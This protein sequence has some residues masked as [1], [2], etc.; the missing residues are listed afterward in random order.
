MCTDGITDCTQTS[1]DRQLVSRKRSRLAG[2][3]LTRRAEPRRLRLRYPSATIK[4]PKK[5]PRT[6]LIPT[7]HP[8]W[9]RGRGGGNLTLMQRL[10]VQ[11]MCWIFPG[12]SMDLNLAGRSGARCGTCRSPSASASTILASSPLFHLPPSS[13]PQSTTH[14]PLICN[15]NSICSSSCSP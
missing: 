10:P 7:H 14:L 6:P 5:K 2:D 4:Q 8:D 1:G 15:R 11:M 13:S 9:T 3:L 12:T